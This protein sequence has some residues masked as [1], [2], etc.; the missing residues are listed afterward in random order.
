MARR[1]G[2]RTVLFL[3]LVAAL[4][5]SRDHAAIA[6]RSVKMSVKMH[7]R[8]G[9]GFGVACEERDDRGRCANNN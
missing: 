5:L 4:T 8:G 7:I 3:V 6:K 1:E 2:G 9:N